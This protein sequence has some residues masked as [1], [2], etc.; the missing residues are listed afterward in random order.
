MYVP[1]NFELKKKIKNLEEA[2][3]S[4]FNIHPRATRMYHDLKKD[5]WWQRMKTNIADFEAMYLVCQ[6]VNIE[7]HKSWRHAA[8]FRYSE[9]KWDKIY[10][11]F[12]V[13]FPRTQGDHHLIWMIV[14]RLTKL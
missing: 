6:L 4:S 14:D 12:V 10:M 13:G 3:K 7:H 2:H 8:I 11:E 1:N 5:F 9:W